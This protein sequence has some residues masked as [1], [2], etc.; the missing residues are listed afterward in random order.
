MSRE[1]YALFWYVVRDDYGFFDVSREMNPRASSGKNLRVKSRY[2]ESF[3]FLGLWPKHWC[4]AVSC[5]L[6]RPWQCFSLILCNVV[7]L[8]LAVAHKLDENCWQTIF[9]NNHTTY[10]SFLPF[11]GIP[12]IQSLGLDVCQSMEMW[13]CKWRHQWPNLSL[14]QVAPPGDQICLQLMQMAPIDDQIKSNWCE[15]RV[16]SP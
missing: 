6:L 2:P 1:G 5:Q 7:I 10:L 15:P 16:L 14:M 8:R 13:K 3:R 11:P 12:G 9:S 4:L